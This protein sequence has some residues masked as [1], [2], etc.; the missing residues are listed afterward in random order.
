MFETVMLNHLKKIYY[1]VFLCSLWL[2][3][4]M[5]LLFSFYADAYVQR[6]Y[7]VSAL[8]IFPKMLIKSMNNYLLCN[9][10]YISMPSR[11]EN[12]VQY[13]LLNLTNTEHPKT[14]GRYDWSHS[15]IEI[16]HNVVLYRMLEK[17]EMTYFVESDPCKYDE[18]H[19]IV[20][21]FYFGVTS[22]VVQIEPS[23]WTERSRILW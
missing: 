4:L 10:N 3:L 9:L 16:V 19:V 1:G 20:T 23:S 15:E 13:Q 5:Y 14:V 2:S 6:I 7:I 21:N 8:C 18:I 22:K 12:D 11:N 17:I